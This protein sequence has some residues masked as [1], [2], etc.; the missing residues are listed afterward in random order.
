MS[1]RDTALSVLIDCRKNGAWMDAALKQ[2]L[3]RDGLDRRDAAL[4]TRLCAA[5]MQNRLLLD[6]WISRFCKSSLSALQPVVL[7]ILR[8]AVCQLRFFDKLPPSAVVNQAVEQTKRLANPRAAALVNGVLRAMLRQLE[9]LSVPQNLSLRYS[10]PEALV[11]LLRQNVGEALLE[12]LLRSH[13]EAPA[14]YLQTNTVKTDAAALAAALE[15]EGLG[16]EPHPWL[17]DCLLLQGGG[18]EQSAAFRE[19][20]FYVQDPAARLA[21]LALAPRRG[22]QILDCCAAPGGKSFAAAIAMENTGSVTACDVHPHKKTLIEKGAAR[23]G[24]DCVRAETR[25][26]SLPEPAWRERF[27]RII[28]DLPCSG[29]G[30]IRKKP[31]IRYKELEPLTGLPAVQ[32]RILEAQATHLKPG[33]TLVYSTCTILRRE[34][35]AL[36]EGFL[37]DHPEFF[38]EPFTL[39]G[40]GSVSTGM[41]TLLPCVEGTDGFFIARMRKL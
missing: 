19:G 24:L 21:V 32:R 8:L 23:L 11:E 9:R 10:H 20:L 18:V 39:P 40:V 5:V 33:G 29:L 7:D 25:D 28:A 3:A 30:V 31:D 34:N 1:A 41:K 27:D 38:L 4:A 12:P 36:I 15:A 35:E 22:E 16:T 17:P 6:E 2:R 37:A 13:N 26:A 14:V